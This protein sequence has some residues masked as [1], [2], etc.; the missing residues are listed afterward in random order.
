MLFEEF[1]QSNMSWEGSTLLLTVRRKLRSSKVG[2]MRW[3]T[4]DDL[5]E[6]YKQKES[7]VQAIIARKTKDEDVKPHPD[8]D[9]IMLYHCWDTE[10]TT[11]SEEVEEDAEMSM[12]VS[13]NNELYR[14]FLS[15][16]SAVANCKAGLGGG[17]PRPKPVPKEKPPLS[18]EE[19][20]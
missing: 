18:P 17:G 6:K 8:T 2:Q 16:C 12:E 5:M 1:L 14:A 3:Y 19:E 4:Q 10:Y 15:D 9:A 13:Y 20:A 11:H 7:I